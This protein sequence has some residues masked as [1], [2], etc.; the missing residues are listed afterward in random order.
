MAWR[1]LDAACFDKILA[2]ILAI[3]T[4][5]RHFLG[6]AVSALRFRGDLILENLISVSNCWLCTPNNLAVE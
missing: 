2:M 5:F 6:W 3:V 4:S 1:R